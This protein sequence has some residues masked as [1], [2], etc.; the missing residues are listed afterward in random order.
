MKIFD[1]THQRNKAVAELLFEQVND[2]VCLTH[3]VE[4]KQ[5]RYGLAF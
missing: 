5:F 3:H 2:G 1:K 4:E